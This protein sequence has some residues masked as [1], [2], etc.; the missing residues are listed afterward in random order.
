MSREAHLE[1]DPESGRTKAT[2]RTY[3]RNLRETSQME[4]ERK[5]RYSRE[6]E[7]RRKPQ[8]NP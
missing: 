1:T 2:S 5:N 8:R 3:T 6:V 7:E 4:A